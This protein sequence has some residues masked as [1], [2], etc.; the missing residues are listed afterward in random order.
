MRHQRIK[1]TAT[2]SHLFQKAKIK[3]VVFFGGFYENARF[4]D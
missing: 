4:N 1:I 3:P 2:E